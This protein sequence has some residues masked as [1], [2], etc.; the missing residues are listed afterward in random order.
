MLNIM[1]GVRRNN[2]ETGHIR[3]LTVSNPTPPN[4]LDR[5]H[6]IHSRSILAHVLKISYDRFIPHFTL[7]AKSRRHNSTPSTDATTYSNRINVGLILRITG[8]INTLL[9]SFISSSEQD[10]SLLSYFVDLSPYR[11]INIL[12]LFYLFYICDELT[13]IA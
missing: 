9:I 12:L 6:I 1:K 11:A 5:V 10:S 8:K 7:T 2:S 4:Y 3:R 13:P